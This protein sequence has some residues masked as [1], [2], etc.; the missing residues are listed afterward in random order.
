MVVNPHVPHY[1]NVDVPEP[2]NMNDQLHGQLTSS[3]TAG[4]PSVH[5]NNNSTNLNKDM[6]CLEYCKT[7]L[8]P[9]CL[10]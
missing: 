4:P 6:V 1:P 3:P 9:L 10:I 7:V 5:Q 8:C 2:I